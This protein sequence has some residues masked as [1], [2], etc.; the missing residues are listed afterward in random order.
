[1]IA[2]VVRL[3]FSWAV[4]VARRIMVICSHSIASAASV[5]VLPPDHLRTAIHPAGS[6]GHSRLSM[7]LATRSVGDTRL[8]MVVAARAGNFSARIMFLHGS[9]HTFLLIMETWQSC[10]RLT[11]REEPVIAA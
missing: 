7:E 9:L 10:R 4:H 6:V 2:S 8:S 3:R 5:L 11:M 1:M